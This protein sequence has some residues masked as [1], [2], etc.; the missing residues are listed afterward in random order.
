[1]DD[2]P[3]I[4]PSNVMES[5]YCDETDDFHQVLTRTPLPA[6]VLWKGRKTH[7]NPTWRLPYAIVKRPDQFSPQ[8]NL[9]IIYLLLYARGIGNEYM[10]WLQ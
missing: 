4:L 9:R 6:V 2:S 1:M 10:R 7:P 8:C 5:S 3:S